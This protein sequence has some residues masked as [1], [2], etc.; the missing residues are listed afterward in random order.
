[1][2]VAKAALLDTSCCLRSILQMTA[3]CDETTCQ[4]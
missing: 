4:G 3:A 1:M 2:T